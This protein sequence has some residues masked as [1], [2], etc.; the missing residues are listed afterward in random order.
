MPEAAENANTAAK[1][2]RASSIL[3]EEV[4]IQCYLF[5]YFAHYPMDNIAEIAQKLSI[6][7]YLLYTLSVRIML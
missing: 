3:G 2:W 4:Y 1:L 5:V 6:G 7:E